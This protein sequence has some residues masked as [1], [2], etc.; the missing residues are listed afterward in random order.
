MQKSK[1]NINRP[2]DYEEYVNLSI[3]WSRWLLKPMGLWPYSNPISRFKQYLHRLINIVCYSL[4]SFLFIPCSL[5]VVFEMEDTYGKLKQFGPLIFCVT[6]FVKYY[7]LIN[8]KADINECV[9]RIKWDWKNTT[10]DRDREIMIANAN[11]G[12]KLVM[13]CTFFMYSGFVLYS[14]VIPFSMGRV[15]AE[16]ANITFYPLIFP[17]TSYVADARYSPLNE[18]VFSLQVLASYL[19]HSLAPAACS[20]AAVL[21][22]HTCGQMQV[23]MNCLKHLIHGRSDMSERLDGRIADIVN[24]HVRVLRYVIVYRFTTAF[25]FIRSYL[26]FR[27]EYNIRV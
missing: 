17:F 7:S 26:L 24:Q 19:I 14:V 5:Y 25:S 27:V 2:V 3:Q 6:G 9:E 4:M 18:I 21:A 20:L 1:I 12:R 23:L 10:N 13:V 8:H 15:T 16:D 11:F 22:V